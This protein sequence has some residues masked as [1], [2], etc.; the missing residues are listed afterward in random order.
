[1]IKSLMNPTSSFLGFAGGALFLAAAHQAQAQVALLDPVSWTSTFG[2]GFTLGYSFTVGPSDLTVTEM[3][4]F[5]RFHGGFA[6]SYD[7]GIWDSI[8]ALVASA[9]VPSGTDAPLSGDYRYVGLGTPVVLQSG[10]IYT[11][12]GRGT[13][14]DSQFEA[15]TAT[16]NGATLVN[17]ALFDNSHPS[18]FQPLSTGVGNFFEVNLML[19]P[20]PEPAAY[21][22]VV[23]LAVLG[24]GAWRR[25]RT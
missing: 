24:F 16:L 18:L 10:H 20:I 21:P 11:V 5:D 13:G 3:G 17:D 4:Y 6:S 9:T 2:G 15:G 19:A 14:A 25:F 12:G 8:G 7:M 23:G 22:A 1:M